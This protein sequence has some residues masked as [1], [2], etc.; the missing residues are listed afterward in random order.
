MYSAE[1]EDKWDKYFESLAPDIQ[2]KVWKKINQIKEGLPGR[3]LKRGL[4]YFVEEVGQYRICYKSFEERR[5]RRFYFV[6]DHKEY[7][8]WLGNPD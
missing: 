7:K 6:G 3:H 4:D 8:K 2:K 1:F 5:V